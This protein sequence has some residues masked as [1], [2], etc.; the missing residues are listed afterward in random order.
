[1]KDAFVGVMCLLLLVDFVHRVRDTEVDAPTYWLSSC[2]N[3]MLL[4]WG[5]AAITWGAT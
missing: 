5:V 3:G 2:F 4:A 1:M